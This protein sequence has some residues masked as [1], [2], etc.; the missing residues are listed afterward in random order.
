MLFQELCKVHK[1]TGK[2]WLC[3]KKVTMNTR[4]SSWSG[5]KGSK[6]WK[7]GKNAWNNDCHISHMTRVALKHVCHLSPRSTIECVDTLQLTFTKI[8]FQIVIKEADRDVLRFLW[9]VNDVIRWCGLP[10][11]HLTTLRTLF[12]N[13]PCMA[14][15]AVYFSKFLDSD[16]LTKIKKNLYTDDW[17]WLW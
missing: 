13:L 11:F 1:S 4:R 12:L 9:D 5:L 2:K 6:L 16:T 7:P 8:F 15:I 10:E 14:F 3:M 17:H